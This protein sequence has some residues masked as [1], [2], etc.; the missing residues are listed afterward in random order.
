[1]SLDTIIAGREAWRIDVSAPRIAMSHE[2]AV[3]IEA[4]AMGIAQE[5]EGMGETLA[6]SMA[7]RVVQLADIIIAALHDESHDE[8]EL[9]YS[10]R[11]RA[12]P[13]K[14]VGHG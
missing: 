3:Q 11:G 1:M 9:Y 8:A 4:L 10:L 7:I 5:L 14:E 2:A 13:E 12:A 6:E